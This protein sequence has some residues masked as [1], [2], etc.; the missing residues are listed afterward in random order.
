MRRNKRELRLQVNCPTSWENKNP[1]LEQK[2]TDVKQ[3]GGQF[4]GIAVVGSGVPIQMGAWS[5]RRMMI[6]RQVVTTCSRRDYD[7]KQYFNVAH[8]TLLLDHVSHGAK[9]PRR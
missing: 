5:L 9:S 3:R 8:E 6:I 7:V 2:R 1:K 4:V